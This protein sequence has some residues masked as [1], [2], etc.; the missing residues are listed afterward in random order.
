[1]QAPTAVTLTG[2]E[3]AAEVGAPPWWLLAALLLLP[4]ALRYRRRA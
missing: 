3:A 2:L 4:L 1:M